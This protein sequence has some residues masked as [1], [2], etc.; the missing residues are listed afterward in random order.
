M[1]SD[2]QLPKILSQ[3]EAANLQARHFYRRRIYDQPLRCDNL[4]ATRRARVRVLGPSR[5]AALFRFTPL[6]S[7]VSQMSGPRPEATLQR[8]LHL[9][10]S[11]PGVKSMWPC[12]FLKVLEVSSLEAAAGELAG[13]SQARGGTAGRVFAA[14][15]GYCAPRACV[16]APGRH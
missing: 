15:R 1:L 8:P 11:F 2:F 12:C 3:A 14:C 13:R 10:W 4:P 7:L 16:C 5:N 9:F 6:L